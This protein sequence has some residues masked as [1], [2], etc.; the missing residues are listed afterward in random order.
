MLRK[1]EKYTKIT[2][3]P[4]QVPRQLALD[5]LHS[6]S[7]IITLNP[8]VLSHHPIKAPQ[9]AVADEYYSTWYEIT[10]RVQYLPG[11][12]KLGSGK[13]SFK[14]SFHNTPWGLQTHTYGPAGVDLRIQWRIGGNQPNE[15][16]VPEKGVPNGLYLREDIDIECNITL[17]SFVKKELQAS[18]KVLVDRLI[19]KAELLDT[20]ALEGIMEDGRL[21]TFNPADRSNIPPVQW[22]DAQK[23]L[24]PTSSQARWSVSS[25]AGHQSFAPPQYGQDHISSV[26][27]E[28]PGMCMPNIDLRKSTNIKLDTSVT[29][30][31]GSK[32]SKAYPAE[33]PAMQENPR[34]HNE[35]HCFK[36][37]GA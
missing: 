3:I 4:P 1:Q 31:A 34:D 22:A 26:T 11:I 16:E 33:L 27:A 28:L 29:Y 24:S 6:H 30:N 7:E 17:I 32:V 18:S 12:G 35:S 14:G 21:K 25:G 13:I 15:P 20:G 2:P 10:E 19:K 5:I 36:G 9:H 8:L 23:P 37:Q